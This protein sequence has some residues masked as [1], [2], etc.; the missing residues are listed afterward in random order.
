MN[1]V[2]ILIV[3][4]LVAI[5]SAFGLVKYASG[6][7]QRAVDA[8]KPVK[9]L[10]AAKDIPAGTDF[11]TAW[12]SHVIVFADTLQSLVPPTA[13]TN[14]QAL[15]G[16][17]ATTELAQGQSVVSGAF[18]D[19]AKAGRSWPTDVRQR[20]ARRHRGRVVQGGCGEGRLR[21]DPSR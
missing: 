9:I 3:A 15:Q 18:A 7:E 13:V 5:G 19:P 11:S 4:A 16:L 21:P 6:A 10:V 8:S 12:N 2:S 17:V 20:P 1:R 14:P